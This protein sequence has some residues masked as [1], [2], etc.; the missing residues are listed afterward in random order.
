MEICCSNNVTVLQDADL[1][2]DLFVRMMLIFQTNLYVTEL[3][4]LTNST[5][6]CL[7]SEAN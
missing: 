3:H 6:I 5:T 1:Q 7:R 2:N 4:Q